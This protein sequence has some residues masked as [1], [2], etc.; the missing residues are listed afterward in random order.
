MF[1]TLNG[2]G[3]LLY[4]AGLDNNFFAVEL[5]DGTLHVAVSDGSKSIVT[6]ATGPRNLLDNQWHLV[7]ITQ[8]DPKTFLIKV[9]QT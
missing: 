3:L 7:E 2:N 4:N 5:V 1:R 8:T 9:D 6:A